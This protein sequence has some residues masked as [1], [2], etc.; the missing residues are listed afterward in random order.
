MKIFVI[1]VVVGIVLISVIIPTVYFR[2]PYQSE[3]LTA[4]VT[5]LV[6][7]QL[8]IGVLIG[9]AMT[10]KTMRRSA[11]LVGAADR[12]YAAQMH[13]DREDI[14][15]FG[16]PVPSA[17]PPALGAGAGQPWLP[18]LGDFEVI[19]GESGEVERG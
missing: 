9:W 18:P 8:L 6:C 11:E 12:G 4:V 5:M 19:D 10:M 1:G 2:S 13:R 16:R 3:I 14:K 15:F 17:Q 7:G